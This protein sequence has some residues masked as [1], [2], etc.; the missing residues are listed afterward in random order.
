MK[1]LYSLLALALTVATVSAQPTTSSN[2]AP[3]GAASRIFTNQADF[4]AALGTNAYYTNNFFKLN[5]LRGAEV[6]YNNNATDRMSYGITAPPDG[7]LFTAQ[8][9]NKLLCSFTDTN[10]LIV[11]LTNVSAVGALVFLTEGWGLLTNGLVCVT[12]SD[13]VETNVPSP[14]FIAHDAGGKPITSMVLRTTIADGNHFPSLRDFYV[15]NP[16]RGGN[17]PAAK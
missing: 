3:I 7:L 5:G 11:T 14:T 2:T 12:F 1:R 13:G 17:R 9:N 10:A 8:S 15:A 4:V 6:D 16:K